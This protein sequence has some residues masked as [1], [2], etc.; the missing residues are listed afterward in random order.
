MSTVG[1]CL[2]LRPLVVPPNQ[3]AFL[4]PALR[5]SLPLY[6]QA[7]RAARGIA[8]LQ[9]PARVSWYHRQPAGN[10]G[11]TPAGEARWTVQQQCL[12]V[13]QQ[14]L[15]AGARSPAAAGSDASLPPAALRGSWSVMP[16]EQSATCVKICRRTSLL[17]RQPTAAACW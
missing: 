16:V 13:E 9:K 12:A 8:A 3:P 10:D 14:R 2:A 11:G 6:A 15:A 1:K 4:T 7:L 5:C 17:R